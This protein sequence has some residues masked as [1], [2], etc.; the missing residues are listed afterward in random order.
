MDIERI[1]LSSNT[2]DNIYESSSEYISSDEKNKDKK[3]I[4]KNKQANSTL[5]TI[6]TNNRIILNKPII[7]RN[8][9]DTEMQILSD[10][11]KKLLKKHQRQSNLDSDD[12][13]LRFGESSSILGHA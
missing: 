3:F 5:N 8:Q 2:K 4:K 1:F 10:S 6:N 7:I 13:K 9:N 11:K 12:Q